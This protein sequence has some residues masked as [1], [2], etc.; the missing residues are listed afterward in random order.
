MWPSVVLVSMVT[1]SRENVKNVHQVAEHALMG[2]W[3][4]NVL[5]VIRRY[6]FK[7]F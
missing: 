5:V 4:R 1:A 2:K 7:V 3:L 6:I